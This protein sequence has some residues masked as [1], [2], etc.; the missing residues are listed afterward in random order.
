[1]YGDIHMHLYMCIHMYLCIYI[2]IYIYGR[3][4]L[5]NVSWGSSY[6]LAN[7]R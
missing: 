5:V 3:L 7:Y 1:M 2:I 4:T 6:L